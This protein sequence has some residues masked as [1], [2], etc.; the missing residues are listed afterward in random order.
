[1]SI[2]NPRQITRMKKR[3]SYDIFAR[4]LEELKTTPQDL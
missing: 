1:M 4:A 2:E 3:A